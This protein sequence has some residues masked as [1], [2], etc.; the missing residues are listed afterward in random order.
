M[1]HTNNA[2]RPD[3]DGLRAIAVLSVVAF[4]AFP[5]IVK[6]GFV[7]VDIFFVISGFLITGILQK[8]LQ[9]HSLSFYQYITNFYQ[10]RITRIFP[11]LLLV[12]T[13]SFVT[14]WFLLLPTDFKTLGKHMLAGAGF[15]SNIVYWQEAGYF[16]AAAE[17]KTLLHL[18]SLAVEEQFYLIWPVLMYVAWRQGISTVWMIASLMILSFVWNVAHIHSQA[19]ATFYSPLTR[20]WELLAGGLLAVQ[21]G[22]A[23]N[24]IKDPRCQNIHSFI[25]IALIT[26]ALY[27]LNKEKRFPGWWALLPVLGSYF[28]ISAG[29]KAWFNRTILSN[30]MI[31][32]IGLISYPLYLWH[33]PILAFLRTIQMEAPSTFEIWIALALSFVLSFFTYRMIETPLRFGNWWK[34]KINL[35]TRILVIAMLV[36]ALLGYTIYSKNGFSNRFPVALKNLL[37]HQYDYGD[38]NGHCLVGI[39]E[40]QTKLPAQCFAKNPAFKKS[41]ALWGDSFTWHL[42][43]ALK[44]RGIQNNIDFNLMAA[45]GCEPVLNANVDYCK[46]GNEFVL[47]ILQKHQYDTILLAG[48]WTNAFQN[49]LDATLNLLNTMQSRHEIVA[50]DIYLVGPGNCGTMEIATDNGELVR[51]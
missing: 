31:V 18:W 24:Q 22:H 4:H 28:I 10:R 39:G 40:N 27:Y 14:G 37:E 36:C 3:I 20:F 5:N 45:A 38:S 35:K 46:K 6:G 34:S 50:K 41:V 33:W 8:D 47:Q 19:I 48:N 32:G 7:G 30:R 29:Q 49:E 42:A 12:L 11:A 23:K 26:I 43:A 2:Y 9:N 21:Q 44:K 51:K 15:V 17:T 16:D 1:N 25:G 13:A